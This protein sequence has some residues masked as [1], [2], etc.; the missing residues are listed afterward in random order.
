MPIGNKMAPLG[1]RLYL[2]MSP[3][4]GAQTPVLPK[5]FSKIENFEPPNSTSASAMQS[6]SEPNNLFERQRFLSLK[7]YYR[8]S[9]NPNQA[10]KTRPG[11]IPSP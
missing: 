3:A 6:A 8:R 11:P 10:V 1:K 2:I 4:R 9:A 5:A 7:G